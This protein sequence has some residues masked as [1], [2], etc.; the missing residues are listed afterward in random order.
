MDPS[1]QQFTQSLVAAQ[2]R[3]FAYVI[4]LIRNPDRAHEVLQKAN[5]VMLEKLDEF[6]TQKIDFIPWALKV[7]YF[8]VLADR[9]DRARDKH[10]FDDAAISCLSEHTAERGET[11]LER[12]RALAL[13][14][15][16]LP[17]NQRE[18]LKKR[19]AKGGSVD[20]LAKELK[21]PTASIS[22]TLYRIREALLECTQRRLAAGEH[23]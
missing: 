14:L 18:M 9:R 2:P 10:V 1:S 12:Q 22:Q 16:K 17:A 7:C 11:F 5:V 23:A 13:C 21:R 6:A 20:A 19:Y 3:L 4:T 15:E 8:E